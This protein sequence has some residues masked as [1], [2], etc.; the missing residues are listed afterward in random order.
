M[1]PTTPLCQET[2]RS[3]LWG[4]RLCWRTANAK[5]DLCGKPVCASHTRFRDDDGRRCI[6][7]SPDHRDKKDG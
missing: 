6:T 5:C 4:G 7:C 2:E 1:V 3:R